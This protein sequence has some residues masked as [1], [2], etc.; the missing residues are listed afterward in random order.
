[1]SRTDLP[2]SSTARRRI[3]SFSIWVWIWGAI[4]L[5]VGALNTYA[6]VGIGDDGFALIGDGENPWD[7][8]NPPLFEPDGN[9]YSGERSGVIRIPLEEHNQVPY[10][11]HLDTGEYVDLYMT[12]AE[13]LDQPA[14]DRYYPDNV[15]DLYEQGDDAFVIPPDGDLELWIRTDAPWQ[16]TLTEADV[17]EITDGFASG[18]DNALLVYRGDALSARF[19][20][21]GD[22]IFFVT[23]QAAGAR[24]ERPIIESG[25][26]N[27][28][29]SWDQ[30]DALYITIE[31]DD[32]RGVWSI[33]IDELA[34]DA[35][36]TPDPEPTSPEPT[37]TESP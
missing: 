21:K 10:V 24:S 26:V 9:V 12:P 25:E 4:V 36:A 3:R 29:I 28:R 16:L 2:V 20:H 11:A 30:T 7:V 33:D 14:N 18:T 6:D 19:V 37:G 13:D 31:A 23:L 17:D 5:F 32:G 22:G 27:E 1:M 35:P 34:T 8:E 15:G